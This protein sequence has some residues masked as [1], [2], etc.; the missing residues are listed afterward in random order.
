MLGSNLVKCFQNRGSFLC[1]ESEALHNAGQC[2][3]ELLEEN[4]TGPPPT[5][6]TLILSR[7][8]QSPRTDR[9]SLSS[10]RT[11][12]GAPKL[13]LGYLAEEAS[14]PGRRGEA[15]PAQEEAGNSCGSGRGIYSHARNP[16][17]QYLQAEPEMYAR[18]QPTGD[19][20]ASMESLRQHE[21]DG[22]HVSSAMAQGDPHSRNGHPMDHHGPP[23]R[24]READTQDLQMTIAELQARLM[25]A[26][27]M[28]KHH[29]DYADHLVK[30]TEVDQQMKVSQ[31]KSQM[32]VETR[33]R[34]AEDHVVMLGLKLKQMEQETDHMR[35]QANMFHT[36]HE[37][38]M[39]ADA[40]YNEA[41]R[42]PPSGYP[43]QGGDVLS[44]GIC[45]GR[46]AC[47]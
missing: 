44:F 20:K 1:C 26:E 16:Q 12:T 7:S 18:G 41:G 10:V 14:Y 17:G 45:A 3:V 40:G 43:H 28:A 13:H 15:Y 32:V 31:Q 8:S 34:V 23:A 36:Q 33:A 29:E 37:Q 19:A 42:Y 6:A 21:Q 30:L 2:S 9:D 46:R 39:Q 35:M 27:A 22:Y 38:L 4:D 24:G 11:P 5:E 25:K 47:G